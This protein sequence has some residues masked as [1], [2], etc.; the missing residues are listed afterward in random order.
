[1]ID[2]ELKQQL[3]AINTNL[4]EFKTK[5]GPGIWRAFFNGMFG[6]LGYV[7][8]IAIIVVALAWILNK[9][10]VLP[11]FQQQMQNFSDVINAAKKMTAPTPPTNSSNNSGGDTTVTLPNGQ[12]INVTLPSGYRY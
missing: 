9:I 12:K 7:V 8:G 2:P 3:E 11:A 5:K 6:A 10:G 1:M 4:F